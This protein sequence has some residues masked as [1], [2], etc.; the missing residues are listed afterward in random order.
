MF[1]QGPLSPSLA[2]VYMLTGLNFSFP[3]NSS[4]LDAKPSHKLTHKGTLGWGGYIAEFAKTGTIL[5]REHATFL[6]IWLEKFIFCGKTCGPTSNMHAMAETL[7]IGGQ[8]P[9]GKH[10]LGAVY[11]LIHQVA[12][13]LSASEPITTLGGLWWFIQM[14]LILYLHK[15]TGSTLSDSSFPSTQSDYEES[16]TRQCTSLGEVVSVLKDDSSSDIINCF[17]VFYNDLVDQAVV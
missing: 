16:T 10:L 4:F 12:I 11:H 13:K 7:S 8:I 2:D 9:L 15:A 5:R 14:W 3:D 6:N 17:K 1:N